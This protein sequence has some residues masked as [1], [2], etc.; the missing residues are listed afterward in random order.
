MTMLD[1]LGE[2]TNAEAFAKH[3]NLTRRFMIMLVAPPC[4]QCG[5]ICGLH[6]KGCANN[7]ASEAAAAAAAQ[8]EKSS[9]SSAPTRPGTAPKAPK[10]SK[11]A[12]N[13]EKEKRQQASAVANGAA[14]TTGSEDGAVP[15]EP[16][17][18]EEASVAEHSE[19][20]EDAAAAANGTEDAGS[21]EE[22]S[23][24]ADDNADLL[25][26][27]RNAR[28]AAGQRPLASPSPPPPPPP[29][30]SK[31]SAAPAEAAPSAASQAQTGSKAGRGGRQGATAS[32][33]APSK[34]PSSAP[35]PPAA[36]T[37]RPAPSRGTECYE[38][39]KVGHIRI[40]CPNRKDRSVK[41][42]ERAQGGCVHSRAGALDPSPAIAPCYVLS[43][44]LCFRVQLS[45]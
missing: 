34:Q 8:K 32:S 27:A 3:P 16:K 39:G 6:A 21:D 26:L 14:V 19:P 20:E 5:V 9:A 31:A 11:K 42:G 4:S 17:S 41:G 44:Q 24:G 36:Q 23:Q 12:L 13:A 30:T 40:N 25:M 10:R 7:P 22:S 43:C 45:A 33:T 29:G 2:K 37:V 15:L 1:R 38:C 18:T 28:P 35:A